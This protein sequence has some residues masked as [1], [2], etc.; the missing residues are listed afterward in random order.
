[1]SKEEK[2]YTSIRFTKNELEQIKLIS[3]CLGMSM[4]SFV[5]LCVTGSFEEM[6]ERAE[7]AVHIKLNK[8]KS[9]LVQP[10]PSLDRQGLGS[11]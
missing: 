4:N 10:E 6:I 5:R 3:N 2:I 8:L 7:K 9:D 1:M 11:D